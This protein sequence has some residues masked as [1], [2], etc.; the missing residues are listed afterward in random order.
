MKNE[1]LS[2]YRSWLETQKCSTVSRPVSCLTRHVY[3]YLC[4]QYIFFYYIKNKKSLILSST[5]DNKVTRISIHY[6]WCPLCP[7]MISVNNF[8]GENTGKKSHSLG[9]FWPLRDSRTRLQWRAHAQNEAF[10]KYCKITL[11]G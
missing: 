4:V 6:I 11:R 3:I 5:L 2:P 8:Q 9:V 10:S 7:F 1:C